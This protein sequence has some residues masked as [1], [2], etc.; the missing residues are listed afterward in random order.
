MRIMFT[1]FL[2]LLSTQ[3]FSM[4]RQLPR[5]AHALSRTALLRQS[6]RPLEALTLH[7]MRGCTTEKEKKENAQDY[8]QHFWKKKRKTDLLRQIQ[9]I[10]D[11]AETE[12]ESSQFLIFVGYMLSVSP[13]NPLG[14][15][16]LQLL[17]VN[18]DS[19]AHQIAF[20]TMLALPAT[21]L[22]YTF[23]A[24]YKA[25]FRKAEEEIKPL[26]EELD[27]LD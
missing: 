11:I 8:F 7:A 18:F 4:M 16:A 14:Y 6:T 22:H 13:F 25:N 26:Q 20:F 21:A 3:T 23:R 12:K 10:R 2:L 9:D 5:G 19:M 15:I 27:Q 1:F 17:N 24:D